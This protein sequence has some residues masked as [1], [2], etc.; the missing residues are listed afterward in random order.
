MLVFASCQL[1]SWTVWRWRARKVE[2]TPSPSSDTS[3]PCITFG[4]EIPV[5]PPTSSLGSFIDCPRNLGTPHS[6][7][8]C[9][10]SLTADWTSLLRCCCRSRVFPP[11]K[12]SWG[13][14]FRLPKRNCLPAW[15]GYYK[16][17]RRQRR[18]PLRGADE[19]DVT[20]PVFKQSGKEGRGERDKLKS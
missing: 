6:L 11:L 12:T 7:T 4:R 14:F 20:A 18:F 2:R 13:G 5:A 1:N 10:I 15:R 17:P 8:H 9:I 3:F 19:E 16:F